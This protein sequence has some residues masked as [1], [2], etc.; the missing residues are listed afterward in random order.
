MVPYLARASIC[1]DMQPLSSAYLSS[2][3]HISYIFMAT[4]KVQWSDNNVSAKVQLIEQC[5]KPSPHLFLSVL[6]W[7]WCRIKACD[8]N[9]QNC[10]KRNNPNQGFAKWSPMIS[11]VHVIKRYHCPIPNM[12]GKVGEQGWEWLNRSKPYFSPTFSF[13]LNF[14]ISF[15]IAMP[16]GPPNTNCSKDYKYSESENV[17][18]YQNIAATPCLINQVTSQEPF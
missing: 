3:H 16:Y 17:Y 15:T 2:L 8:T 7:P 12:A 10:A 4:A 11:F 14:G 5:G 18:D 6:D 13:R 9:P 1:I